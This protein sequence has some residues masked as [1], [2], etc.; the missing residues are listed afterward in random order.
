MDYTYKNDLKHFIDIDITPIVDMKGFVTL[1]LADLA[2]RET[3]YIFNGPNKKQASLPMDYKSRIE[4]IMYMDNGN[5]IKFSKLIN[6][7]DYYEHQIKWEQEL[8]KTISDVI[9]ELGKKEQTTYNLETDT[10]EIIFTEEEIEKIKS[11]YDRETLEIM[12]DF[13]RSIDDY[14]LDRKFLINQRESQRFMNRARDRH[15]SFLINE[16]HRAGIKYPEKYLHLR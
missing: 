9:N 13:S 5:G 2:S 8:G 10:I 7:E 15:Q 12:N 3:L 6:I 16:L 14:T 4:Q 1:L 11:R